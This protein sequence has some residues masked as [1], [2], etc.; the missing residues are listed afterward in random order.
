M[1]GDSDLQ[2]IYSSTWI[3]PGSAGDTYSCNR[4]AQG[5]NTK[6]QLSASKLVQLDKN[7]W[8]LIIARNGDL[9]EGWE[10]LVVL[11]FPSLSVIESDSYAND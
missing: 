11:T 1:G 3:L 9:T 6:Y 4:V 10:K 8:V 5:G 2:D 7:R